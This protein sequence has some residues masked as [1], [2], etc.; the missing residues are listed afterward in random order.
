MIYKN[1]F[2]KNNKVVN[3][4]IGLVPYLVLMALF[5]TPVK[6]QNSAEKVE[7]QAITMQKAKQNPVTVTQM[8]SESLSDGT[9]HLSKSLQGMLTFLQENITY[10]P[11][12]IS[13][14]KQGD[15]IIGFTVTPTGKVT[16][17]R[18]IKGLSPDLDKEVLRNIKKMPEWKYSEKDV[19]HKITINFA[20]AD[21]KSIVKPT[22]SIVG[23]ELSDLPLTVQIKDGAGGTMDVY[24]ISGTGEASTVAKTFVV[25][26]KEENE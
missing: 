10:V 2:S 20:L 26:V 13:E 22:V 25:T 11:K 24:S 17:S 15:L 14:K 7:T 9:S 16:K 5:C 3:L 1:I 4:N 18:I 23:I 19:D 8:R 21:G 6:A 12:A